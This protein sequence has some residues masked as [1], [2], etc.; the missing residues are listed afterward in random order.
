[1][2]LIASVALLHAQTRGLP[3][4]VLD[5]FISDI[6]ARRVTPYGCL[7]YR[8]CEAA[9]V[10]AL[11]CSVAPS[12][13]SGNDAEESNQ[14]WLHLATWHLTACDKSCTETLQT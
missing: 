9:F 10:L 6:I 14:P 12:D 4:S 1:M 13:T 8:H 5:G 7:S 2:S 3:V 11:H